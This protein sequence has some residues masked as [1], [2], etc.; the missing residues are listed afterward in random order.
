MGT[1]PVGISIVRIPRVCNKL[2]HISA[3][4]D[5]WDLKCD[6]L[7]LGTSVLFLLS[8]KCFIFSLMFSVAMLTCFFITDSVTS[9]GALEGFLVSA[10]VI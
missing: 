7:H 2:L 4:T 10:S 8:L 5:V 3:V 9:D 6:P 1:L